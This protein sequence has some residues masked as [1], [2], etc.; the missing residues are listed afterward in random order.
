[1]LSL[2]ACS[3]DDDSTNDLSVPVC[4][5]DD[6]P[7][8]A[9]E[10]AALADDAAVALDRAVDL[11]AG[12]DVELVEG[13]CAG[14]GDAPERLT[15]SLCQLTL[16]DG[17]QLVVGRSTEP[18]VTVRAQLDGEAIEFTLATVPGTANVLRAPSPTLLILDADGAEIGAAITS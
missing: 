1:M 18:G 7:V 11:A 3:S 5:A 9:V 6:V 12:S 4:D 14:G 2:S 8:C 16:E 17:R 15:W 13:V 10:I